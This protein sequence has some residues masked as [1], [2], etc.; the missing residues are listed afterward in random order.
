MTF[1]FLPTT[2]QEMYAKG[3]Q[4]IDIILITGD[5]YI[6]H[7]SFG[8]ALIGR[9]LEEHGYKVGIIAQPD[10]ENPD[11]FKALG[12]PNLFFGITAGNLDSMIANYTAEK[13]KRR[14]DS[15]SEGGEPGRRPDRAC[16]VYSN[17]V[18]QAFPGVPIVL[19]G[20][21]A[22]CRRFVHYDY[23]SNKLRRSILFDS[24]ADVLVYGMGEQSLLRITECIKNGEKDFSGI[25]NTAYITRKIPE[26]THLNLA[27]YETLLEN[28]KEYA[29]TTLLYAKEISKK[30][31]IQI[32]Q[33][34]QNRYVV[35]EP[36]KPLTTQ[37]L[38]HIYELPFTRKAHP[39]YIKPVPANGFVKYSVVSHRGCYGGCSFC[40]LGMHQGKYI[41]SRSKKSILNEVKNII[42]KQSDF[43]GSI[44][45]VGGP[46]ANMYGSF[47][48]SQ[49]GCTRTSC[50]Y[51]VICKNLKH[52]QSQH[53]AI[54]NEISR[55][56]EIKNVFVNSGVRFD[57]ALKD[58]NYIDKICAKH[59]SGQM[60]IAPEHICGDV[61]ALMQ[62]PSFKVYKEYVAQFR[63]ASKKYDK[64]QYL[65]PYF[66][67]AHPG[68]TL[69][70]MYELSIYLKENHMR[71]EQVQN[72]IPIPLTLSEAM[73][74]SGYDVF[75]LTKIHVPKEE[76]RLMQ[77]ALLQPYIKSN[78]N[79]LKKALKI[80]NKERSFSFLTGSSLSYRKN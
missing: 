44:L 53:L 70:H 72:Y 20:L 3:W 19:G 58:P 33:E 28:K 51:P 24:R 77:R 7:P 57:L 31:S 6:D 50:L 1:S 30:E 43:K 73:Y 40:S 62:K 10:W 15:Y 13:R 25:P 79:L 46:S 45:D 52:Q 54:L 60:S 18:R 5:A 78:H 17:C 23:W 59:V 27:S 14:T 71:V 39:K 47:C 8:A 42:V 38:D 41:V 56:P 35:V 37:E 68:C 75:S 67:A 4:S 32:I 49:K 48:T 74:Y 22:S 2:K 26:T 64:K 76:E 65:I 11:D 12:K 34:C 9:F 29:R 61:L 69:Q 63:K 36:P 55:V 16:L 80:L 66:I 21:E